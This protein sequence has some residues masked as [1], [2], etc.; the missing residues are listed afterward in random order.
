MIK[1][2]Q[3]AY[4]RSC[5]RN[6]LNNKKQLECLLIPGLGGVDYTRPNCHSSDPSSGVE[7]GVIKYIDKKC[8]LEKRIEI[9]K[10]TIEHYK[11]EDKRS[12]VSGKQKYIFDRF[13]R[14]FTY[15]RAAFE[16]NISERTAMYW[17]EDIYFTAECI[18]EEYQLF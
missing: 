9:V 7:N 3:R 14:R 4:I 16:C 2:E 5:F 11:I 17:E 10:R 18:A 8:E 12:G 6:Y 13:L 1:N 15:R